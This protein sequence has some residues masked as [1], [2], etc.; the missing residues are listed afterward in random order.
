M[1]AL[2]KRIIS[3]GRSSPRC[4]L[5]HRI[6]VYASRFTFLRFAWLRFTFYVSFYTTFPSDFHIP[7]SS[8]DLFQGVEE[9]RFPRSST[10]PR[11]GTGRGGARS[12]LRFTR[13]RFVS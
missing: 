9:W 7:H 11:R 13:L 3:H 4:F 12:T 5:G 2:K 10:K 1:E 6:L 8:L